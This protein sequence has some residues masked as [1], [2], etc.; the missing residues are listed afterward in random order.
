[1]ANNNRTILVTGATGHQGGAAFHRL[2]Q[3]GFALRALVR[4]PEKP[5]ARELEGSGV[6]VLRG[7]FDDPES[8]RR[9]LDGAD[10]AYSVQAWQAGP[11]AE[12][13]QGIAFAEAASRQEIGHFVY[14]S[15]A[16]ADGNT[17]IPHFES[18]GK[19]ENRIRQIGMPYTIFRPV[20]FMENWLTM[21]GG[22][23]K[24][25]IMLPLSPQTRLQMIAVEDIGAFVALAFEHPGHW[26][27]RAFELAG[28]ELSMAELAEA[29]SRASG[30][31]VQ[32]R[33]V[34][35]DEF[36]QRAGHEMTL[37]Y[38]WFEEK[39]YDIDIPAVR[40]QYP[41]LT[42]FNRWLEQKWRRPAAQTASTRS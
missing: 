33:Q 27:N 12:S 1:M 13:R 37:M 2:R 22:I 8:I 7:D 11:E 19:I 28:D 40:Q 21:R 9:A 6:E 38:R 26:R 29:F 25:A 4:N 14:S 20:F 3:R 32:Y 42:T 41:E 36:E 15:V 39:G 31:E 35:W 30:R 5:E 10:G 23:D 18:K 34:P 16:A 24:G 17:G